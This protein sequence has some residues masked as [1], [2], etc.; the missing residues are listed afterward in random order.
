MSFSEKLRAV[1][2][3]LC[4]L[5]T[6]IEFQTSIQ[7]VRNNSNMISKGIWLE[8]FI[9]HTQTYQVASF[10]FGSQITSFSLA[11]LKK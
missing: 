2:V 6:P 7:T 9:L 8:L 1:T 4:T 3:T 5:Y 10:S 11:T